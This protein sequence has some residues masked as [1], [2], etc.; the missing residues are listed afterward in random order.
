[1]LKQS[2]NLHRELSNGMSHATYTKGFWVNSWLFVVRS[3]DH[4]P[5]FGHNLCLMCPNGSCKPTLN[6]YVPRTFQWYKEFP[7][8][9]GFNVCDHSLKIWDSIRTLTPK[10]R[11]HL[12]VGVIFLHFQPPGS[13]KCYSRASLLVHTLA[14]PCLSRE[15]KARVA[16]QWVVNFRWYKV[17]SDNMPNHYQETI[18]TL[19]TITS[20]VK[21][22]IVDKNMKQKT[23]DINININ[24]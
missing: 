4:D 8:P 16:T 14:S 9:M 22:M 12:G 21:A 7:N 5:S 24:L 15:P 10:M 13:M 19:K 2:C 3:Q 1:M 20:M 18:F 17:F 6:I 23:K 11:A